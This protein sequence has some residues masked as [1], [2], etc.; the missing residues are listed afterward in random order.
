MS[1]TNTL[2]AA[3][4][5]RGSALKLFGIALLTLA[6]IVPLAMLTFLN[7]ERKGRAAEA[8]F[9]VAQGW[10]GAQ[11]IA[12]PMLIVPWE[13]PER[14]DAS[15]S[16]LSPALSGRVVILPKTLSAEI[17][18]D[19][20]IRKRGIFDVTV[21]TAAVR[22]TGAF[23]TPELAS[24]LP[25]GA[26]PRWDLAHLA[27]GVTDVR[28]LT[29]ALSVKLGGRDL[30]QF[31]PGTG[32]Q[33][34]IQGVRA[35][36]GLADA[37]SALSF[38]IAFSVRGLD[39]LSVVPA[40]EASEVSVASDWPHPSFDGAFLP[41]APEISAEGFKADWSV[42]FLSRPFPQAWNDGEVMN[43]DTAAFG[44]TFY[45]PVDHYQLIER[46]LKYAIL[47]VGLSFLVFF[48]IE[49]VAGARIH[50]VQYLLAGSAQVI[51]YLLLLALAEQTGFSLAYL[52]A[53]AACSL[54]TALYAWSVTQ[55]LLLGLAVLLGL[56]VLYGLLYTL[57]NEE[58]YA[59][60]TG[61]AASFAALAVTMFLTRRT[62]WY[63]AQEAA[64]TG[65]RVTDPARPAT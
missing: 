16:E 22:L 18:A 24:K 35:P 15:G 25:A 54:L 60:L 20:D 19:S 17:G 57:L 34:L 11:Q 56:S 42:S 50:I 9:S 3:V 43:L 27:L 51:F 45:K 33:L 26:V 46:A 4:K 10:G 28:G 58:D 21:Y 12:G 23:E 6:M 49:T 55:R 41:G 31:E 62:D 48:L 47:F 30:G 63:G 14:R 1:S 36:A 13:A 2:A 59:L 8:S 38:E 32:S 7:D 40:G 44:V 64:L 61:A 52:A 5:G 39:R 37:P 65:I 53:A 29:G